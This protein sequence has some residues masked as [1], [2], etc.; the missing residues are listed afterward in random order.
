MRCS[1]KSQF[2]IEYLLTIVVVI[3]L[4]IPVLLFAYYSAMEKTQGVEKKQLETLGNFFLKKIEK[5]YSAG[6]PS[7]ITAQQRVPLP[8]KN[9]TEGGFKDHDVVLVLDNNQ[10]FSFSSS[11]PLEIHLNR[12]L[13]EGIITVRFD[14]VYNETGPNKEQIVNITVLD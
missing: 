9:I 1:K 2:S 8:L 14:A 7:R 5:V 4:F 12:T 3:S 11:Y 6:V 10:N 13:G